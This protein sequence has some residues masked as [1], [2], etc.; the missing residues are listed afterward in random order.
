MQDKQSNPQKTQK[1]NNAFFFEIDRFI[2]RIFRNWALYLFSLI[3]ALFIAIY[4][5]NWYLDRTYK[6]DST[7]HVSTISSG[8]TE[9]GSNSINFIWGGASGKLDIL[10]NVLESRTHSFQVAKRIGAYIEY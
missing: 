6:A 9:L 2:P 3:F 10:T 8:N 7:F 1:K 4:V 5:N